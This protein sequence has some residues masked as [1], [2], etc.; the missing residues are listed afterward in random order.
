M[1]FSI[2]RSN[3]YGILNMFESKLIIQILSLR[4]KI[5]ISIV[6]VAFLL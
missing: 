5:Q 2:K 1:K 6:E 4:W 3:R